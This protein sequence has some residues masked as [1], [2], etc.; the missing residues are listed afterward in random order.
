METRLTALRVEVEPAQPEDEFSARYATGSGLLLLDSRHPRRWP[1]GATIDGLLTLDLTEDR[2]LASAELVW[3]RERW[4][5][6]EA[7]VPKREKQRRRL[8]FPD[9]STEM[10]GDTPPLGVSFGSSLVVLQL[11]GT[12]ATRRVPLGKYVDCLLQNDAAVG[13]VID[14]RAVEAGE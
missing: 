13:F 11:E 14:R 9:L 6:G 4:P 12:T 5:L 8:R 1:Y 2:V 3:P 7:K 10:L